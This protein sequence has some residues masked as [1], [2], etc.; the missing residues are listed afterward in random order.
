M[1]RIQLLGAV[2]AIASM[3]SFLPQA[4]KIVKSRQTRDISVVMYA[5][6]VF[7]FACWLLYGALLGQLPL[8]VSNAVCLAAS[9][10]IL[11]MALLPRRARDQV[12]DALD[13]AAS[14]GAGKVDR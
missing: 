12:A 13:P 1:E 4:W 10:F 9:G 6:T 5:V 3:S 8:I 2:A 11:G 14:A 7:G